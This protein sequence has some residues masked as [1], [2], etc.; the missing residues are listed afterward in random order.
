MIESKILKK[1][2]ERWPDVPEADLKQGPNKF[3]AQSDSG[4]LDSYVLAKMMDGRWRLTSYY[5]WFKPRI[6]KTRDEGLK[7]MMGLI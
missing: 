7:F 6:F 2:L 5:P 4:D 1:F 3:Y